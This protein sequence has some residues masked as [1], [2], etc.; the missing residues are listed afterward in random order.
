MV[1][2]PTN[3]ARQVVVPSITA[4]DSSEG[5]VQASLDSLDGH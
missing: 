2:E 1:I 3:I 4:L 5:A